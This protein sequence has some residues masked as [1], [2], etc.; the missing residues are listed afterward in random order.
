MSRFGD[1]AVAAAGDDDGVGALE[2]STR[3]CIFRG[4]GKETLCFT[5][6]PQATVLLI[7]CV[8]FLRCSLP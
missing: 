7:S 4:V 6:W 1:D 8:V 3:P 5:R 2:V